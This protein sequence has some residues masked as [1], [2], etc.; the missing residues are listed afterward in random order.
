[1]RKMTVANAMGKSGQRSSL[2]EAP[3]GSNV[4]E[5]MDA[6]AIRMQWNVVEGRYGSQKD[7]Q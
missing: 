1:M 6:C 4:T 5:T 3:A 7:N 2:R